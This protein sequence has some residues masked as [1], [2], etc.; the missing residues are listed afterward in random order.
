MASTITREHPAKIVKIRKA[1]N[2]SKEN[3]HGR[4]AEIR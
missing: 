3:R 2:E 4:P 1:V